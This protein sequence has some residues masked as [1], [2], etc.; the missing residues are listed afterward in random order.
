MDSAC[1]ASIRWNVVEALEFLHEQIA[2]Q[3]SANPAALRA[4]AGDVTDEACMIRYQQGDGRAFQML[5]F[6][7][8]EKLHRYLL[9]LAD[10]PSEAEEV[11]Q[12]VWMAVIRGKERYR[13]DA[14][15]AAWLFSVAHRRASDRWRTLSRHAP[16]W[17][18]HGND[19]A[20]YESFAPLSQS[21]ERLAHSDELGQAI[22]DA[23]GNLPL[24]Q[25]EA[26]L[27]KADGHLSLDDI[28][29]ATQVSRETVK[30]RLR[31]AQ[32]R[33]RDALESWR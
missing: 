13:P 1:T 8:R 26:F 31:Y 22:L 30:S 3:K 10:R 23:I 4:E 32:Q 14:S 5:Y 18:S 11:F 6:R 25:R 20:D 17:Q 16:D 27:M 2:S 15:F 19:Q 24:P 28:A 12:E 21:P 9:R 33:L 29:M 7:Y